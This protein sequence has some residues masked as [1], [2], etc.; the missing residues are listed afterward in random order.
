LLCD[1]HESDRAF[2]LEA[3]NGYGSLT[4]DRISR[5]TVHTENL[6]ISIFGNT[7]PAKLSRYLHYAIRGID[8]DG[9]LQ[10]FQLLI[11]PDDNLNWQ[12]VDKPANHTAKKRAAN[13]VKQLTRMNYLE[14]GATI[15]ANER[16]PFYCFDDEEQE[17]IY[18][19]LTKLEREKLNAD[20]HPI[21]I[22]HFAKYRSLMPSLALIFHLIDI[23]DGKINKKI[24]LDHALKAIC[25]CEYLE[26]HAR[27]IYSMGH[28]ISRQAAIKLG[29][30]IRSGALSS[31][32]SIRDV[33]RKDWVLL[34]DKT[35]VQKACEELVE[36]NW[37]RLETTSS[38][39]GRPRLPSFV[40]NPK[41][42]IE[43]ED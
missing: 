36:A 8:N 1:G 13:I 17:L 29:K 38:D 42:K 43:R 24:S 2:F 16:F 32:F 7:Q 41:V 25:W 20:D 30:K 40:V 15:E 22:E 5:G 33:Y 12:L 27:R 6:C 26:K 34:D 28:D 11:Y 14:F 18:V 35:L 23:A 10:R 21:L 19:W 39:F 3:W 37:L 31:P 9:L 4:T